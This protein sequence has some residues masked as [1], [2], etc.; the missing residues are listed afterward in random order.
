MPARSVGPFAHRRAPSDNASTPN[1]ER[2]VQCLTAC[3]RLPALPPV[4]LFKRVL[5]TLYGVQTPHEGCPQRDTPCYFSF[6]SVA[7]QELEHGVEVVAKLG[8]GLD[9]A[10]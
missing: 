9:G 5:G 10:W 8:V 6:H 7:R 1:S 3:P 4:A 2:R